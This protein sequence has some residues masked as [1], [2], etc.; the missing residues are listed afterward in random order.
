M[1]YRPAAQSESSTSRGLSSVE[2]PV[3]RI[4][5]GGT[6]V[7]VKLAAAPMHNRDGS[8]R[9]VAWAVE[10]ITSRRRVE[11]QLKRLAHYDPLTGLP[12]RLSLQQELGRLLAGDGG[13][14][15]TALA[16]FDLDD[17]KDVND[18]L[19]HSMGDQLLV[20]IGHRLTE[21]SERRGKAARI[22]RLSGD[23]FV[24]IVPSCGDPCVINEIASAMLDQLAQ[25]FY[26]ADHTLH[27]G[28]IAIAPNDGVTVDELIANADLALYQAK[29]D[30][31]SVCRHFQP[32]LRA[33]AQARRSLDADLRRAFAH[34]ELEIHFQPQVRLA[35]AAIVGAEAL[36]RHP[37][38]GLLAPGAFINALA[39]SAIA[40]DVGRWIMRAAC[41]H[42]AS[43]RS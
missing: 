22:F 29:A 14:R 32:V 6:A 11:E 2:A 1:G 30:G 37:Q 28:G 16:L 5:K 18:T 4:R 13:T 26:I 23:E 36:L 15:P 9:G 40:Q 20:E 24:V 34:N 17:F 31:G 38:Q 25:P 7:H 39:E 10:Y 21:V 27:V 41:V 42:T 35:D 33:Q 3:K 8:V 12:N 43:W 19:G